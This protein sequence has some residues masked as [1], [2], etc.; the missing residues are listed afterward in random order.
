[1]PVRGV[2][3]PHAFTLPGEVTRITLV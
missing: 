1:V 2:Q 3:E